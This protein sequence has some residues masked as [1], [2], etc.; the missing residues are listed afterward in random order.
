MELIEVFFVKIGLDWM[1]LFLNKVKRMMFVLKS[2]G[3][4]CK[5]QNKAENKDGVAGHYY[6]HLE[7]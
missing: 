5:G 6:W 3:G 2:K 7:S 1:E 4:K